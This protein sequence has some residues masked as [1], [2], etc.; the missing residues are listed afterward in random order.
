MGYSS[1]T[2]GPFVLVKLISKFITDLALRESSKLNEQGNNQ[3]TKALTNMEI[4]LHLE[5]RSIIYLSIYLDQVKT[6]ARQYWNNISVTV[7]T[8]FDQRPAP[9]SSNNRHMNNGLS[10]II[11]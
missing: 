6:A 11:E 1:V 8:C 7:D 3:V 2:V 5:F 9:H 4:Y 10:S